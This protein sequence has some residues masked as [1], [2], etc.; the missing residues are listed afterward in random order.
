M[1][2]HRGAAEITAGLFAGKIG[3]AVHEMGQDQRP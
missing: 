2:I 3:D 1:K